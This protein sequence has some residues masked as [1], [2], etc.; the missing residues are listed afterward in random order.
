MSWLSRHLT[1]RSHG[2]QA[3]EQPDEAPPPD[4]APAPERSRAWGLKNEAPD[5]EYQKAEE[6]CKQRKVEEPKF[7][8]S[9]DVDRIK[10]EGAKAW[11]MVSPTIPHRFR[12]TVT[13]G[14]RDKKGGTKGTKVVEIITESGCGDVCILSNYPIMAGLYDIQGKEGIYYEVKILKMEGI[15]AIGACLSHT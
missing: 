7:L 3:Q 14:A 6:F 2:K 5:D 15:I 8:A 11:E 9:Y 4:W 12:G 1:S 10:E 13:N